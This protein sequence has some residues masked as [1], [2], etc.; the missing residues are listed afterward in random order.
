[1]KKS[2]LFFALVLASYGTIQAQVTTS[3]MTGVVTAQSGQATAGA[4]I[5]AVHVPSGTT[6][7]GASNGVG[8][9]NLNGMRVGGP[10]QVTITYIGQDPVVYEDVYLQLGQPF[11]LNPIF[12]DSA[13]ALDEVTI[14]GTRSR[15]IKT[16]AETSISKNQLASL[17]TVSRG[18]N[19]FT[20][21][22]P[23][24]DVK[25]SSVS[26]GGVNNRFNQLTIDGA[27]SNDVF[28]LNASGTNGGGTGTSPISLD[29]IEQMTVQIAPFDVRAS[30]FAGG[31]ISAV[32]RSGTN[33]VQ[34]SAYFY[35]RNQDLTGK[36][37]KSLVKENEEAT[38]LADFHERQYGFRVG[39]PII[40]N[41]LFFFA[42]YE[43]TENSIPATFEV[44]SGASL[45]TVAE[46]E[47]ALAISKGYGY[48]PGSYS[49]LTSTNN[50]DKIFTRIDYN[51]N[52]KHKLALRYSL[53]QAKDLQSSIG[54]RSVTFSNG[55]IAK[56][57]TTHSATLDL[58]SRFNDSWSNNLLIG[59]T[60]VLDDRGSLGQAAP[61]VAI[62]MDNSRSINL[63]PEAFSTVNLLTQKVFTIT[64]NTTWNSGLHAVT[65]GTH[66]EFYKMYNGF[67]GSAF[68]S[69]TFRD[70]PV[71]DVNPATGNPF[72]ALENYERGLAN[73]FAYNYSNNDNPRAGADVSAMQ[74]GFY[75]Q[76]EFQVQDNLKIIGG[77]RLDIP[78]YTSKP[79]E[80]T[81]FNQSIIAVQ[82]DVQTNRMPKAA[83]MFSP[84]LGF[85]WDVNRDRSTVVRG[86]MGLFTSRFPFVWASGA[87]TQDG[88]LLG[89]VNT[90]VS[91]APTVNFV[92]NVEDQ[93]KGPAGS[94]SGN[95]SV[96][97]RNLKVPQIAR[98]SAAVD[99]E[100]PFGIR[101]T[102]DFM[103]SK[104]V[105]SFK[106]TD[107]N[108]V[109]PI[110][111]LEGADNR[112]L[113]PAY[114][115]NRVMP[116]Y[117][118][119]IEISNVNKGYS[120]SSTASVQKNFNF[121]LFT[122]LAY[123]YTESKDLISGTSSQ[124]QSNF[125]RV[126]TVNGT[127]SATIGHSPFSTGSRVLGT[128]LF[129]KEYLRNLGTTVGLVYNGQSGARYS[130]LIQGDPGRHAT[131]SASNQYSLMYIPQSQSDIQF[132][133]NGDL[134][135]EAQWTILD[136]YIQNDKYLNKNRG[137]YAER[138]GARTPFSHQFDVKI[139]QDLIAN[140]GNTKNK[141]Q[142]SIDI[143]N[144]GNLLNSDWGKMYTGSGSF[145]DNEAR[146]IQFDSFE[147][148]TNTPRYKLRETLNNEK[149]YVVQ[150]ISSR[151]SA[152]IGVRYIF[153]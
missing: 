149:P 8:R 25:G 137:K 18:L 104:N 150:A 12:G 101:G 141:L 27:V 146:I 63:G 133:T 117:T 84:R 5:K 96:M 26:I 14:T 16:G 142:L 48:D 135:P 81:D 58:N 121:G 107:L 7:A 45:I 51:I 136:N 87:Y 132:V 3:S 24:A 61:R 66:N 49:D 21:L 65:F 79:Q 56:D 127:N 131:S 140:I 112:L 32:T 109:A 114:N 97:N 139:M 102:L 40:K 134:T 76:D 47:K 148:G 28:G 73:N 17:P 62:Q 64:N 85:N 123:T 78:I 70:S 86:G 91:G 1:M 37:P 110:G 92:P 55:G 9:F 128:I 46:A 119:V 36:T 69:Y 30:G 19:D 22:T 42:N 68:G 54:E 59:Y 82:H 38:K 4:S 126:A 100:L 93:P 29:A 23:Q 72:T 103:Y 60:D 83:L 39:G 108:K 95:I 20:R 31:G 153:N 144:F 11:V 35:T 34:G 118:E 125:Y 75:V 106:F 113:Y 15:G 111:Q 94:P 105:S 2:L 52:D 74:L 151:W 53:V 6:Y 143:M 41:K 145:W 33:E 130:Y 71:S 10:Y 13:T 77:I 57:H 99:Q 120:W 147:P 89:G 67:I 138:N 124:N 80:N 152:Q 129:N 90:S 88:V 50:S 122:S 116:N 98:F 43:R 115:S 44:G